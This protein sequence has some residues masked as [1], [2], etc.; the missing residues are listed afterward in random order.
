M[1]RTIFILLLSVLIL[2]SCSLLKPSDFTY[3]FEDRYTGLDTLI[4]TEGY[5]LVQRECDSVFNSA[6]MFY[7]NGLFTILTGSDLSE[8]KE[9]LADNNNTTICKNIAWGVY[10]IEENT[11]K[12]QTVRQEGTGF[13]TIFRDYK[14][15][16]DKKLVNISDYV[17]PA[18]TK[19][20]Y[21]KNYP[22]F[23]ENTCGKN[24]TFFSRQ[25]KRDYTKC[26][27]LNKKWFVSKK[28]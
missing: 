18:N 11:I 15:M 16:P 22:S 2:S 25:N 17:I 4:S 8:A 24:A 6:F 10:R 20:G 26:P 3:K 7:P 13:C 27:Y 23:L 19:I 14:I 1:S 28:N 12:T 9:C 21:M 5:Y